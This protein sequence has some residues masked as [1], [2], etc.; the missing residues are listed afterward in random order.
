M[1]PVDILGVSPAGRL[2]LPRDF[3]DCNFGCNYKKNC[4]RYR[5]WGE[6]TNGKYYYSDPAGLEYCVCPECY[7]L[8]EFPANYSLFRI[9]EWPEE[10]YESC[11]P[12][13]V[14]LYYESRGSNS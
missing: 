3:E 4:F 11:F 10:I 13:I 5:L 9:D 2:S 7:V 12:R 1:I 6:K 8:D 14:K